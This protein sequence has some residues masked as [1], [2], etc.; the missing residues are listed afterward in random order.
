MNISIMCTC[1]Q[2]V[3]YTYTAQQVSFNVSAKTL[4]TSDRAWGSGRL[5]CCYCTDSWP[6][7]GHSAKGHLTTIDPDASNYIAN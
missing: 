3:L 2:F 5:H 1:T 6:V 7:A 4:Q